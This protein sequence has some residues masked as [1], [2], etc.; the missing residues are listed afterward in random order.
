MILVP[1]A[2]HLT[3]ANAIVLPGETQLRLSVQRGFE[4]L[5]SVDGIH[6]RPMHSGA[7]V[8]ITRSPRE[9]QFVRLGGEDQF[10]E[11][12]ARRLGWLRLDHVI[13]EA[14]GLEPDDPSEAA[15]PAVEDR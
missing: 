1:V 15:R 13:D 5:L 6:H 12:L 14:Q 2:P 7:E 10:Y 4:A 8:Q 9:V 11:N 3:R